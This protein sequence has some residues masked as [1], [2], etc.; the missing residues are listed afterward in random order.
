[1]GAV[2]TRYGG[3]AQGSEWPWVPSKR[4]DVPDAKP[5]TFPCTMPHD[6]SLTVAFVAEGDANTSDCW[7]GSG[8]RFVRALRDRGVKVDIYDAEV[9]SWTRALMALLSFHP[10]RD[11]WRQRY[12][13]GP[14][15]FHARSARVN[16]LLRR[17]A[18]P[19][20]AVIQI[21][22][23][24]E[25]SAAHRPAGGYV[26]YC[27]A[28]L[29]FARRGAPFSAASRLH[30]GELA[31]VARRERRVYDAADRIWTMSDEL[32][33][34]FRDDFGQPSEKLVTIYAGVNNPASPPTQART[35]PMILF[36]GKDHARKGSAV[37]LTAFAQIRAVVPD[38][39]L[40]FVGG[41]P[42][43]ADLPGVTTH[44][45]VSRAT[46]AGRALLDR[47]FAT[48]TVFCLPSR[49]EPFGIAFAEAM[50]AGLPCVGTDRWAMPEIIVDGET[51]WLVPDGS[52]DE[53]ARVLVRMLQDPEG[54][55]RMGAQG[56]KRAL[57]RF[58]WDLV[59]QRAH[60]DLCALLGRSQEVGLEG[61]PA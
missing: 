39:E 42:P 1:M 6:M 46:P 4:R 12:G 52:S 50:L 15:P 16:S 22:G 7:S 34:C 38:A 11:R 41:V 36:V 61:R 45:V 24:F 44:G 9:R 13:L 23:T 59:A 56:R 10:S 27:D 20:D 47:L 43:G 21:G 58:T 17:A 35:A 18:V 2:H 31:G 48:A 55:A 3:P 33:R 54:S 37:L 60:A 14:I 28:N 30:A 8:E 25:V 57:A 40:H 5:P 51:G 29:A 53:L 32:A 19:Y 49:Y 26:L